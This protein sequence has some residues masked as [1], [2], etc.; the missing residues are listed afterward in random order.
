MPNVEVADV[1]ELLPP[2]MFN[3][4][5]AGVGSERMRFFESTLKHALV[6]RYDDPPMT[7]NYEESATIGKRNDWAN[8]QIMRV[9]LEE[10]G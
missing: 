4:L 2:S 9:V 8:N 7:T 1:S 10:N 6:H 5:K 3:F